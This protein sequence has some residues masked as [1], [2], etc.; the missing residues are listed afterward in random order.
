MIH[1]LIHETQDKNIGLQNWLTQLKKVWLNHIVRDLIKFFDW[2]KTVNNNDVLDSIIPDRWNEC[3]FN[4][5]KRY[6]YFNFNQ[7]D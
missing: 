6:T 1:T 5:D 2:L 3:K 4:I 7:V